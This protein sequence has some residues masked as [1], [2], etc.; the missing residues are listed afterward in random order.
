M[1]VDWTRAPTLKHALG[2]RSVMSE[3]GAKVHS[4]SCERSSVRIISDLKSTGLV[5]VTLL[6]FSL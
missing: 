6:P 3:S 5:F 1:R 4:D 2:E